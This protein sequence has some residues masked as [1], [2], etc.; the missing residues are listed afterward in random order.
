[1]A[2]GVWEVSVGLL[3]SQKYVKLTSQKY[4]KLTSS[5]WLDM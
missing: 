3:S 4:V 2:N 5:F 1:M